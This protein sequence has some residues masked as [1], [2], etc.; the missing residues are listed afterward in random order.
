MNKSLDATSRPSY[1]TAIDSLQN[2]LKQSHQESMKYFVQ[3]SEAINQLKRFSKGAQLKSAPHKVTHYASLY[4]SEAA[5]ENAAYA[6]ENALLSDNFATADFSG[7]EM[8][9]GPRQFL[10]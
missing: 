10:S 2:Q 3:R 9:N 8:I 5:Y 7:V 1:Q 4:E 6:I